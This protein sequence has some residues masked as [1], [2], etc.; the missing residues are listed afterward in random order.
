[1]AKLIKILAGALGA[2]ILLLVLTALL[3][4]LLFDKDDLKLA[5]SDAVLEKTGRELTIAAGPTHLGP[6]IALPVIHQANRLQYFREVS[7]GP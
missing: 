6:A 3:L 7:L 5:I 2:F 4:P 1:M